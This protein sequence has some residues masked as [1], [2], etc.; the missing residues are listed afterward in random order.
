MKKHFYL[1]SGQLYEL[2]VMNDDCCVPP[3]KS[4]FTAI[5]SAVLNASGYP[6]ELNTT[7]FNEW[8]LL[9]YYRSA[10]Q[11]SVDIQVNITNIEVL[12][13][14][15]SIKIL[16]NI[17]TNGADSHDELILRKRHFKAELWRKFHNPGG[18]LLDSK[19]SIDHIFCLIEKAS[20]IFN[21]PVANLE[22]DQRFTSTHQMYV[23]LHSIYN[24]FNDV[25]KKQIETTLGAA[26]FYLPHP[27]NESWNRL[28]SIRAIIG[29]KRGLQMV[30]DH[31]KPRRIVCR[32]LLSLNAPLEYGMFVNK[33]RDEFSKF[34]Y[35][36]T[37]ENIKL[38]NYEGD[39]LTAASNLGITF[40]I[41][42]Q[43]FNHNRLKS[44][45]LTLQRIDQETLDG[46]LNN[47][48]INNDF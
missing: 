16:F 15:E 12:E 19:E 14:K 39:Y 46:L 41:F 13:S 45:L 28:V 4:Y 40:L 44:T 29:F 48:N 47:G 26:L 22:A 6:T 30:K 34:S 20:Q 32:E 24:L 21:N 33:F 43:N 7:N 36:T 25:G 42:P 35:V 27:V 38:I 8:N 18:K 17:S 37:K 11:N 31:I 5:I 2:I 3:G 9:H 10:F 23:R 1:L